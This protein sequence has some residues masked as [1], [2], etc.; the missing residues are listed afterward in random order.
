MFRLNMGL[1]RHSWTRAN[2]VVDFD[3]SARVNWYG[4]DTILRCLAKAHQNSY[5]Q[6]LAM[7]LSKSNFTDDIAGW[8]NF[9]CI[10]DQPAAKAPVGLPTFQLF[11]DIDMVSSRSDWSGDESLVVYTAGPPMGHKAL[12]LPTPGNLFT[13][14]HMHPDVGHFVVFACGEWQL[15]DDGYWAD[16]GS[17]NPKMTENHN[18]LV[19]DG[20]N[21]LQAD[22]IFAEKANPYIVETFSDDSFDFIKSVLHEAYKPEVGLKKYFRYLIFLK[23]DIL[24]IIDE[25]ELV[26]PHMLD[27]LFHPENAISRDGEAFI[28]KGKQSSLRIGYF[29]QEGIQ[30]FW[31]N[32]KYSNGR[33]TLPTLRLRKVSNEWKNATFLSWSKSK[34]PAITMQNM[35][36]KWI[37]DSRG[38]AVVFD[39]EKKIAYLLPALSANS[40]LRILR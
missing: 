7:E 4:P 2:Q 18:T 14:G 30:S 11:S 21:Q 22:E 23:P 12:G 27:L 35:G 15:R 8:L 25:L 5:A 31:G 38:R 6:W 37:F 40:S 20:L 19:I 26:S 29:A 17:E 1:P 9:I 34:P 24:I 39:W 16:D 13:A 10:D 28:A 3:D 36:D 33:L 32:E